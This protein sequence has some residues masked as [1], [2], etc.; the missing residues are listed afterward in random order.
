MV[1]VVSDEEQ[2]GEERMWRIDYVSPD[3]IHVLQMSGKYID[4]WIT[5]GDQAWSGALWIPTNI[6][7]DPYMI[8]Q[9]RIMISRHLVSIFDQALEHNLNIQ[10]SD[11]GKTYF[12][13]GSFSNFRNINEELTQT[14]EAI[15]RVNYLGYV[16]RVDLMLEFNDE[17]DEIKIEFRHSFAAF[18][19]DIPIEPPV[20]HGSA[21]SKGEWI[22]PAGKFEL[23]EP[24]F[25]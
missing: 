15:F 8:T 5:I 21:N 14:Y 11:D 25:F 2:D 22:L 13:V 10:V 23:Y 16:N 1:E 24:P 7:D 9:D 3:R 12:V 4:E 19:Q 18:D 17:G 6:A 20:V